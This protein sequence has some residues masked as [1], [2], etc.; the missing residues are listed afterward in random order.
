[1]THLD[2]DHI[3]SVGIDIGTST[4]K[5]IVSQLKL[6]R[7]SSHFSLPRYDIVQREVIYESSIIATPLKSYE[8]IDVRELFS[9]LQKEYASANINLNQIK[10]GAVI[11]T[12][13]TAIKKNADAVVHHLA[14]R[15]GDFVV[16]I[17]GASLEGVLAGK[18]S[19][20]W[21]LSRSLKGNV[22]NV[23]IGGGTANV[24]VF[25]G[26]KTMG[27]LTFKVGGRL[28]E[29]NSWGVVSAI[30]PTIQPWLAFKNIEIQVGQQTD[31]FPFRQVVRE[32]CCDMLDVLSGTVPIDNLETMIHSS[33]FEALPKIDYV[34]FSGGVGRLMADEPPQNF[35]QS[36]AYK[37][38][39]PL[40][41]SEL[42]DVLK[43][44][45]FEVKEALQTSRATVI[46]AGMQSTE[47]SGSTIFIKEDTLPIKNIPVVKISCSHSTYSVEQEERIRQALL[48]GKELFPE[49]GTVPFAIGISGLSYCSYIFL[50]ELALMIYEIYR[51]LFPD[52][53][54]LV[55]VCENDIAKALGQIL[56]VYT[57]GAYNLV[58]LDEIVIE[59]GDYLD[60]G[61]PVQHSV[62]PVVIKTLA[63]Q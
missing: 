13:E 10:S 45:D 38:I 40:L 9:W 21:E 28:I 16:A 61:E 33:S 30:S 20:A 55:F 8:E 31:F 37:D 5:F 44:Y 43:S 4:S 46:G 52:A 17:A 25:N 7:T 63:L 53:E 54:T 62:I 36:A 26:G 48:N 23:D 34:M 49:E 1:M 2:K 3:T 11:I 12:G 41:A 47:V 59:H 60:I 35:Q 19:G 6:G 57:T 32:L 42:S 50:K 27:T 51:Q 14:D 22:A 58:C 56:K 24:S 18:G 29:L 39:G 15:S